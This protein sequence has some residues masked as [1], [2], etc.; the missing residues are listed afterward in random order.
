MLMYQD[1]GC[2][3]PGLPGPSQDA[4]SVPTVAG[5]AQGSLLNA[6]Y[7]AE[8]TYPVTVAAGLVV[9]VQFEKEQALARY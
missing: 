1:A 5:L 7:A 8:Y 2:A 9:P 4:D 3:S 6:R